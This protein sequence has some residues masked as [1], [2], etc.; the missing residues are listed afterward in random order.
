M[1]WGVNWTAV[2]PL[3][4]L[5]SKRFYWRLCFCDG[6]SRSRLLFSAPHSPNRRRGEKRSVWGVLCHRIVVHPLLL[7]VVTLL[8]PLTS[9]TALAQM[10]T[11]CGFLFDSVL[12]L[13]RMEH[14]DEDP[15]TTVFANMPISIY[16]CGWQNWKWIQNSSTQPLSL[17]IA[18][19]HVAIDRYISV[20][21]YIYASQRPP[22]HAVVAATSSVVT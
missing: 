12:G 11:K 22:S 16:N 21:G 8:E 2:F 9:L 7:L 5:S 17:K 13:L 18:S 1:L 4:L 10:R 20:Y 3:S 6:L 14:S 19:I 15:L